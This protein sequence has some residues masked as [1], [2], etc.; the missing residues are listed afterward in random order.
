[1]ASAPLV[2]SAFAPESPVP[3]AVSRGFRTR[4]LSGAEIVWLAFV[5][6]QALDGGLS[7]IGVS[8]HGPGIEANP[9]V[10][11]YL[12]AFG[13]AVGFTAAKLFAITCGI[14]LYVTARHRWMAALTLM[15]LTL[16]VGPWLSLLAG[17]G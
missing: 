15:Y 17:G 14:V 3:S 1:M 5:T 4:R 9:L 6:V 10:A 8:L 11:W 2:G 16:A 13:P 7:Y 12:S